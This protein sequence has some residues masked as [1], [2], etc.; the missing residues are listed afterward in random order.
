MSAY[1]PLFDFQRFRLPDWL[2]WLGVIQFFLYLP[3]GLLHITLGKMVYGRDLLLLFSNFIFIW[4]LFYR[5]GRH[6]PLGYVIPLALFLVVILPG[7]FAPGGRRGFLLMAKIVAMWNFFILFGFHVFMNLTKRHA[8]LL[9]GLLIIYLLGESFVG[10]LESRRIFLINRAAFLEDSTAFGKDVVNQR[11]LYVSGWR[12]L[13]GLQRD[14]Y[15]FGSLM[16]IG[17]ILSWVGIVFTRFKSWSA[18]MLSFCFAGI[19]LWFAYISIISGMRAGLVGI[20]A[21]APLVIFTLFGLH[22]NSLL[23]RAYAV[24]LWFGMTL[25]IFVDFPMIFSVLATL[26]LGDLPMAAIGSTMA[27]MMW[28]GIILA[29]FDKAPM[30][31]LWG[32]QWTQVFTGFVSRIGY[33]DNQALFLLYYGGIPLFMAF[34]LMFISSIPRLPRIAQNRAVPAFYYT[35]ILFVAFQY[36]ESFPRETLMLPSA[37]VLLF[38][39]GMNIALQEQLRQNPRLA[40]MLLGLIPQMPPPPPPGRRGWQ[41]PTPGWNP[42]PPMRP[43]PRPM[44][45]PGMRRPMSR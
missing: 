42:R 12:R 27:R 11:N 43:G 41:D 33:F 32:F 23:M 1:L 36:G 2:F 8:Q 18:I 45:Q 39:M 5:Q 22:R 37:F 7:A 6:I 34:N 10:F 21:M 31:L 13:N 4:F 3:S 16:C 24:L 19:G 17:W 25:L 9:F 44:P 26:F 35:Y 30:I 28:W 29:D 20:A 40:P 15:A 38:S 14:S